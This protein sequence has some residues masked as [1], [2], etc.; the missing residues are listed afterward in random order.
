MNVLLKLIQ[1]LC[2]KCDK[3]FYVLIDGL[4]ENLIC[5]Y[6]NNPVRKVR[7]FDVGMNSITEL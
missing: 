4:S 7:I 5:P 6:C 3:K 1:F 2:P